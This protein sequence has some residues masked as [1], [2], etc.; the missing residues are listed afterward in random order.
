MTAEEKKAHREAIKKAKADRKNKGPK[1][2]AEI[3]EEKPAK[4]KQ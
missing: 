1:E 4:Q 3:T 2:T